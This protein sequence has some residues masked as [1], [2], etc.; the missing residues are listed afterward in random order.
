M[1]KF[2]VLMRPQAG[3]RRNTVH[4]GRRAVGLEQV[5]AE[6]ARRMQIISGS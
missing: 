2:A 4:V 1:I 5:D 3:E 6:L